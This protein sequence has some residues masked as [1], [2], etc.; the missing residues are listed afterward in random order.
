MAIAMEISARNRA[1]L[2][3]IRIERLK[4]GKPAFKG[5]NRPAMLV[6]CEKMCS[7][8]E[9]RAILLDK[10]T[11]LASDGRRQAE[12]IA[13]LNAFCDA[14]DYGNFQRKKS[15]MSVTKRALKKRSATRERQRIAELRDR[16]S[17]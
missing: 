8:D 9:V 3:R 11:K 6:I 15:I 13:E 5:P 2:E 12:I 16:S 17:K 4:S 7:P 1:V 10:A 14:H